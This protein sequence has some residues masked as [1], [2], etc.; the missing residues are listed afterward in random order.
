MLHDM[1]HILYISSRS[2]SCDLGVTAR[3]GW[4]LASLVYQLS[5]LVSLFCFSAEL[6]TD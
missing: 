1:H 3:Q 6:A 4:F 2:G 5:L